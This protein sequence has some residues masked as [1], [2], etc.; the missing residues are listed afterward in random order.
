MRRVYINP[1]FPVSALEIFSWRSPFRLERVFSLRSVLLI[2]NCS[3]QNKVCTV[4]FVNCSFQNTLFVYNCSR[5]NNFVNRVIQLFFS[6]QL[7]RIVVWNYIVLSS[8]VIFSTQGKRYWFAI[9]AV[10]LVNSSSA[11]CVFSR[12]FF[13]T[14]GFF[15]RLQL[16]SLLQVLEINSGTFI[17]F[18]FKVTVCPSLRL[19]IVNALLFGAFSWP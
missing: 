8:S 4:G 10:F 6:E 3:F 18:L 16:L 11:L 1:F 2:L 9:S 14:N 7:F 5:Q 12:L 15:F 13:N 17:H 19:S